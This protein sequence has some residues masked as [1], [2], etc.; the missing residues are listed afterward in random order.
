MR[1]HT[2]TGVCESEL[3]TV[4]I[5]MNVTNSTNHAL[6][7]R[8]LLC[9]PVL[10]LQETPAALGAIATFFHL[11]KLIHYKLVKPPGGSFS[12]CM[13]PSPLRHGLPGSPCPHCGVHKGTQQPVGGPSPS[14]SPPSTTARGLPLQCRGVVCPGFF[15]QGPSPPP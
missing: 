15:V 10:L 14:I 4:T 8:R 13:I 9:L 6:S 1:A 5:C 11:K 2:H 7:P 12:P 3:M